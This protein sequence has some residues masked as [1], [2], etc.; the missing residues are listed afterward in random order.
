L[1]TPLAELDTDWP[2]TVSIVSESPLFDELFA[3]QY[4]MFVTKIFLDKATRKFSSG[5]LIHLFRF[6]LLLLASTCRLS[7]V[8]FAKLTQEAVECLLGL[9]N[10]KHWMLRVDSLRLTFI[11][12]VVIVTDGTLV[13]DANYGRSL[14]AITTNLSM[15]LYFLAFFFL[16]D[17]F[18]EETVELRVA[19]ILDFFF[20]VS[21]DF[22]QTFETEC[23]SAVALLARLTFLV[24]LG[25]FTL[26]ANHLLFLN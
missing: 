1:T 20:D 17:V 23:S 14:A 22:T 8:L 19:K 18:F 21:G 24:H 16:C 26:K 5:L 3:Y 11:T 9:A 4:L 7:Q 13:S 6:V 12:Q 2:I 15:S 25:A 10:L